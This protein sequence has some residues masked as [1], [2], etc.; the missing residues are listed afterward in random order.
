LTNGEHIREEDLLLLALGAL[1]DDEATNLLAHAKSC[2]E[3]A[4]KLAEERGHAA[5]LAFA[6][7]QEI[8]AATVKVELLARIHAE[9]EKEEHY[10]WPLKKD[11]VRQ[12]P[13]PKKDGTSMNEGKLNWL[14]WVLIPVAAVFLI[15]TALM[16]KSNRELKAELAKANHDL[17]D[18]QNQRQRTEM[19]VDVLSAPDT[20]SVRMAGSGESA[21]SIGS[22]NY[23]ARRGV[24]LY[25]AVLP[26]LPQDKVYQM[27]LVP[28][29]GSPISAGVFSPGPHGNRELW[30]ATIPLNTQAKA[31]AVTIEPAGGVP[32]P[33]GPKVLLGAS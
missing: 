4:A 5:T 15:A 24:L 2:A 33:T 28:T 32:Q 29:T 17:I 23:N 12:I 7:K 13:S 11:E 31:F 6:A 10:K 3:C 16:W 9:R 19:I 1:P 22:A 21:K 18:I 20:V 25:T 26:P 27:W 30:T 8:P 14:Q